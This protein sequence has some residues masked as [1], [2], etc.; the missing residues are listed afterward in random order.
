MA[1]QFWGK[2]RGVVRDTADPEHHARLKAVVPSVLGDAVT[3]WAT[4]CVPYTPTGAKA[5][6]VPPAGH[7]VWIEFEGGDI[8]RPIWSGCFW[9]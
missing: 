8:S 5:V 4:P 3:A 6:T 7:P 1:Q 9:T 2:Y